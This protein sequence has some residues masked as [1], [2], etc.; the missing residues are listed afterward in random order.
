MET[1]SIGS[2][3]GSGGGYFRDVNAD[4]SARSSANGQFYGG[5][6]ASGPL[7][8]TFNGGSLAGALGGSAV[9]GWAVVAGLALAA[10]WLWKRR[11]K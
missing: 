5:P 7:N 11:G 9:P 2:S 3:G 6:F 4:T 10:W 8:V 1:G